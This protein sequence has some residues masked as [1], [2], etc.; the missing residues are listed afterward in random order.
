MEYLTLSEF[1]KKLINSLIII[2]FKHD[3]IQKNNN[4]LY[5]Y[6]KDTS[7]NYW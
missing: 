1:K 2:P 7:F 3:S 5:N 6:E 4:E